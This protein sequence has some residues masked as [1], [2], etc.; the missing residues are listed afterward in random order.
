MKKSV[1]T[2]GDAAANFSKKDKLTA[3]A[4]AEMHFCPYGHSFC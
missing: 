2:M 4:R 3:K 1:K